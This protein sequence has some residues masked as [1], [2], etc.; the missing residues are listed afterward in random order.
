M[1]SEKRKY[2]P[3]PGPSA[4]IDTISTEAKNNNKV[5]INAET[6]TSPTFVFDASSHSPPPKATLRLRAGKPRRRNPSSSAKASVLSRPSSAANSKGRNY[7][8]H[9]PLSYPIAME[10]AICDFC[11]KG[12]VDSSNIF[13]RSWALFKGC[14]RCNYQI[15]EVC[16]E[17]APLPAPSKNPLPLPSTTSPFPIGLLPPPPPQLKFHG[18]FERREYHL[19]DLDISSHIPLCQNYMKF[20]LDSYDLSE[21]SNHF[22]EFDK[23]GCLPLHILAKVAGSDQSH[24]LD[25]LLVD[26]VVLHP[27]ALSMRNKQFELPLDVARKNGAPP[28]TLSLLSLNSKEVF[29]MGGWQMS[30]EYAPVFYWW[31]VCLNWCE[32]SSEL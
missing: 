23:F 12:D 27:Y 21:L 11:E 9:G 10:N 22:R 19:A 31:H 29:T 1:K 3:P 8:L 2:P 6:A 14:K 20:Y 4:E 13:T 17:T 7:C 30:R 5:A 15:C 24:L 32:V 16:Y 26:A 18:L 28:S 25:H